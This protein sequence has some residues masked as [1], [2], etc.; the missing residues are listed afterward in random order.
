M[1][2]GLID[3]TESTSPRRVPIVSGIPIIGEVFKSNKIDNSASELIV[4]VTP[5]ILEEPT[6]SVAAKT[7]SPVGPRE[8]E[9]AGGREESIEQTL[10]IMEKPKL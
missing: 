3:R 4:F 7:M 8:Q 9:P 1:I 10:N 5:K 6:D 2:G